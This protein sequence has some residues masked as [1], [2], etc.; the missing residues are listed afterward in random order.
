MAEVFQSHGQ[1]VIRILESNTGQA[2]DT[3]HL[4]SSFTLAS[5]SGTQT[6]LTTQP[7]ALRHTSKTLTLS[8]TE[9]AFG[10]HFDARGTHREFA[11]AFNE[12]TR[13]TDLRFLIPFSNVR[14]TPY[15]DL[16]SLLP[17]RVPALP[18][19]RAPASACT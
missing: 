3:Q 14:F 13:A 7:L 9:I 8:H 15:H 18:S 6:L 17:V 4:F 1:E 12:A 2:I 19:Q 16:I 10:E 11:Q 5:F